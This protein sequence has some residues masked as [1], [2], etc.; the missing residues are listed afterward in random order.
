MDINPGKIIAWC[1]SGNTRIRDNTVF[2]K[3]ICDYQSPVVSTGATYSYVGTGVDDAKPILLKGLTSVMSG[4]LYRDAPDAG[5]K[6]SHSAANAPPARPLAAHNF[7]GRGKLRGFQRGT[8]I[9]TQIEDAVHL[10]PAQF[11]ARHPEGIHPWAH[12][13]LTE[14]LAR[15]WRPVKSEFIVH[16]RDVFMATRIDIVCVDKNGH[17][18]L[19]ETK[20][21]YANGTFDMDDGTAQW[22][23]PE[24]A[25]V[26]NFPCTPR[27]LAV[28]QICMGGLMAHRM[29]AL[30]FDAFTCIVARVDDHSI[31][32]VPVAPTFLAGPPT[33]AYEHLYRVRG[34][35]ARKKT[36]AKKAVVVV[37]RPLTNNH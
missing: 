5:R 37:A 23:I 22:A 17:L 12:A 19:I 30:P 34:P 1:G 26:P 29:L 15:G 14:I 36:A 6:R 21:G 3:R 11:T 35:N 31:Q 13:L 9:H 2:I 33:R 18:Y 8:L 32:F 4:Y 28:I 10:T 16:D 24:L 25:T 7:R 20:S 27:N